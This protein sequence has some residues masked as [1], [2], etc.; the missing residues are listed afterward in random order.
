MLKSLFG[1]VEDV[2]KIAI[3]PVA[4]AADVARAVTKPLADVAEATA[5]EV[6]AATR[7]I[8]GEDH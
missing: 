6:G 5:K 2:A 7:E 1:I 4:I 8:R 3:T